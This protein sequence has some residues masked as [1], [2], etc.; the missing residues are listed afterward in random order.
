MNGKTATAIALRTVI[1]AVLVLILVFI[2][3]SSLGPQTFGS[4]LS[5]TIL[6]LILASTVIYS[7]AIADLFVTGEL[8]RAVS[9]G[10]LCFAVGLFFSMQIADAPG[11]G[12]YNLLGFW[13]LISTVIIVGAYISRAIST[14]HHMRPFKILSVSVMLLALGLVST[15]IVSILSQN[16][17]VQFPP[18]FEIAVLCSFAVAS[19]LC[20]LGLFSGSHNPYASYIGKKFSKTSF[21]VPFFML[22]LFLLIYVYDVRPFIAG[23]Y[24]DYLVPIE[25]GTIVVICYAI[26]R[27]ARSYVAESLAEDLSLGNWTRL[28][29]KIVSKK[30]KV[31]EVSKVVE[32]FVDEGDK[33]GILVYLASAM[34]ENQASLEDTEAAI[35]GIVKYQD[36]PNPKLALLSRLANRKEENKVRRKEVLNQTFVEAAQILRVHIPTARWFE[37]Q[38]VEEQA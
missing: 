28:V 12:E 38:T 29:Q 18:S 33:T 24:S 10:A 1:F 8:W 31:D 23:S 22:T 5:F 11:I 4:D 7:V 19:V 9:K 25:W 32:K 34:L 15:Q 2:L 35:R 37:A 21:L 36:I 17:L 30:S 26:Y 3:N 20:L 27:N 16:A 14:S 13:M 6:P